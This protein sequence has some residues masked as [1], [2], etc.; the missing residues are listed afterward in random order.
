MRHIIMPLIFLVLFISSTLTFVGNI[1][2]HKFHVITCR[3]IKNMN[4][5]NR[6]MFQ[7]RKQAIESD[8]M[9]CKVCRP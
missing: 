8:Y 7:S 2:T 4:D 3:T 6:I 9:P 1:R 5:D